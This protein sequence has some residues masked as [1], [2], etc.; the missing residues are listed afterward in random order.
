MRQI[1]EL[2]QKGHIRPSSSPYG[3]PIVLVQ[4]KDGTW[5]LCIDYR[6]LNKITVWNRY[7]HEADWRHRAA[8]HQLICS[9]VL[10][11]HPDLQLDLGRAPPPHSTGPPN[12]AETQVVCQFGEVHFWHDRGSVSGLHYWWAWGASGSNQDPS[13]PGLVIQVHIG[14]HPPF[15]TG[16][17]QLSGNFGNLLFLASFNF[18][19]HFEGLNEGFLRSRY[20]KIVEGMIE[21]T[22]WIS[23]TLTFQRAII[24]LKRRSYAKVT[25]PGSWC[26]NLPK[27]GPHDFCRFMS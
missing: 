27:R 8:I 6:A 1:Q 19:G 4:K 9:S 17:K 13:H 2:L 25:T 12:I 26:T 14:G 15:P 24:R 10:G 23:S 18:R 11:W 5:R 21:P 7:L 3:S 16:L 22:K 20:S